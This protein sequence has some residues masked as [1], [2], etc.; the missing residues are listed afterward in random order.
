MSIKITNKHIGLI[1][2]H[3]TIMNYPLISEYIEAI[4]NAEENFELLKNL[5]PVLSEDGE[6]VMTS[7]NFAVVF[8]M[9]DEQ[10]GNLNAVKCFLKE[11]EGRAE[12]Y[13]MIAE[14]LE[15]VNS[16][17]LTPIKY[18]EKELFVD[19]SNSEDSEFPIL[20][21]DWVEG[22][23]LDKYIRE[24][25]DDQYEL[26]LL[27]YRFSRLAMWLV[28]Q[29]F[30]HGDLKPDNIL[31][32]A[33]GTLMLVDY[34]GMYV[35]SMKG[36][37]ARELGS[38]DFRHPS[39][40]EEV[41][42]EHIDDFSL[43]SILL[44]LKAI[45]LQPSLM[46]EYGASDRLL[47]SEKDY[48][49]L[50]ESSALGTLQPLMQDAE[51]ASLYSLYILALSQNNLSQVSFRLFNLAKPD[52]SQYK[53]EVF[54]TEVTDLDIDN[55]VEDEF[56]VIYSKDGK[57]LLKAND[58][59]ETYSI[60]NGTKVICDSA[61]HWCYKLSQ[62]VI[63]ESV[64]CIGDNP[65]SYCD[66]LLNIVCKSKQYVFKNGAIFSSDLKT[67]VSCISKERVFNIPNGV[68]KIANEAFSFCSNLEQVSIPNSV[69]TIGDDA[70]SACDSLDQITLPHSIHQIGHSAFYGCSSLL[71]VVIPNSVTYIDRYAFAEC[72]ISQI[73][74][75]NSITKIEKGVF[76][77]CQSLMDVIIPNSVTHIEEQ[78]FWDCTSL[79]KIV[80][81]NSI[82]YIG[83][84]AF[85]AC[86]V[87]KKI[88]IPFGSL[89]KFTELLPE[90]KDKLIE[91][92]ED[93]N[94]STE[95]TEEDWAN[96]WTDEYGVMY[97]KDRKRLLGVYGCY[98]PDYE[99]PEGT[100]VI[101]DD[102]LNGIWTEIEGLMISGNIKIPST[103]Q[104]IGRNPFRGDYVKIECKSPYFLVED[105]ALYTSDRKEL[106]TCFS[107][108]SEFTIP[109]GVER[110]RNFAFYD[111]EISIIRIP[112]SVTDIGD[113][114]FIEMNILNEQSLMVICNSPSFFVINDTLYKRSPQKII[115]YFGKSSFLF[116]EEET[117]IMGAYAFWSYSLKSIFLPFSMKEI[118]ENALCVF[119]L[120]HLLIPLNTLNKYEKLLPNY[121]GKLLEVD[122]SLITI[123]DFGT[124]YDEKNKRLLN[125]CDQKDYVINEE[126]KEI[127]HHA[128]SGCTVLTRLVIP[129]SI[130]IIGK[131]AF[132][133]CSNL[134]SISIPNSVTYI[135]EGAF[136]YCDNLE[137]IEFP[138][139]ITVLEVLLFDWCT[140][141]TH[142]VI[143]SSVVRIGN[144]AFENCKKLKS[145]SIPNSV[146]TFGD[147]VFFGCDNLTTIIIPVGT[148][149]K[150]EKLL[151]KYKDKLIEKSEEENLSTKVT[152]EDLANAWTDE[153][154]AMYSIDKT[155]L[156]K[157]PYEKCLNDYKILDG[158]KV[159]GDQAFA[160][161]F[162]LF[163][164]NI[165]DTV[166]HIGWR[167]FWGCS[168]LTKVSLPSSA[169]YIDCNAF[170]GC[171]QLFQIIIPFGTKERF[172]KMLPEYKAKLIEQIKGWTVKTTRPFDAEEIAAVDVADVVDSKYGL[173][174]RF[175]MN[176][177]DHTGDY[178]YIPLCEYSLLKSGD[179][180]DMTTAKLITLCREGED[181]I[182]RVEA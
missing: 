175:K 146:V 49:N 17:F 40:T 180:I 16:T 65:F 12:A 24:H 111:C 9:K 26:S 156:L 88:I 44:S 57:R 102:A 115:S 168:N 1:T 104:Y 176:A 30:A 163:N 8:K 64:K 130:K 129:S 132:R 15:Y 72:P 70:F 61:F 78:A 29:P 133:G 171:A 159:L 66:S 10:T 52:K 174:V 91:Q 87:L 98:L 41:F 3:H 154:G 55:G 107:K 97:S 82:S 125:G 45:A 38:P 155:R 21:M 73:Y 141:L 136:K 181:D 160:N 120:E 34:D 36:Q 128:F 169:T 166:T 25:I 152:K 137:S 106:I 74:I 153:F 108:K 99:I 81:P 127:Y 172:E 158:T 109:E 20:L 4:K 71:S 113:N 131:E 165:P 85:G 37:K 43:A 53:E 134:K 28:P 170:E 60:K 80:L 105:D 100:I 48:R 51:L 147:S 126:T 101:C 182:Y 35:P 114:P 118:S 117:V 122:L 58:S 143:P 89:D 119:S 54:N 151:P 138:N 62:I 124:I 86:K 149:R 46:E 47:F 123:D 178:T 157:V 7:G 116:L 79:V 103:V 148:I 140:N 19:S 139:S 50:S 110:I 94:L 145:I 75:P 2:S 177:G 33:D 150:F 164:V 92:D 90:Y 67:I 14:E 95:V 23:T 39:R 93:E 84:N 161:N 63:P 27:A 5:R 42:D 76:S 173:S 96:A 121:L 11:Q 179:T 69:I 59:V 18:L 83:K 135:G 56:G 144:W 13:R 167:V 31:V 32:K 6:P 162:I 68:L 77:H 112:A 142:V 22:Q